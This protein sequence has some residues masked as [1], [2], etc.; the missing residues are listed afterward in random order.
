MNP[1]NL[2]I[3]LDLGDRRTLFG[4]ILPSLP[5]FDP[6]HGGEQNLSIGKELHS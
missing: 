3:G 4:R 1:H 6:G 5:E 2:T